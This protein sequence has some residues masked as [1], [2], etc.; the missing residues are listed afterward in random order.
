MVSESGK[1]GEK[2]SEL[3]EIESCRI[4]SVRRPIYREIGGRPSMHWSSPGSTVEL[5]LHLKEWQELRPFD[6]FVV[7][8]KPELAGESHWVRDF[9]GRHITL[10]QDYAF[11]HGEISP[12]KKVELLTIDETGTLLPVDPDPLTFEARGSFQVLS[13]EGLGEGGL[14]VFHPQHDLTL[15]PR[16]PFD[17]G[18]GEMAIA[19]RHRFEFSSIHIPEGVTVTLVSS[20]DVELLSTGDVRIEGTLLLDTTFAAERGSQESAKDLHYLRRLIKS[21]FGCRIAA[22][23]DLEVSGEIRHL[24]P[25]EYQPPPL[26]LLA[27]TLVLNG[28]VPRKTVLAAEKWQG[29]FQGAIQIFHSMKPGYSGRNATA[30]GRTRWVRLPPDYVGTI[31]ARAEKIEGDLD[32]YLQIAQPDPFDPTLPYLDPDGMSEPLKLPLKEPLDVG[33]GSHV[34]FI[35]RAKVIGGRSLPSVEKLV[36]LGH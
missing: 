23:G 6:R 24:Y 17:R 29:S 10:P 16:V 14:G 33:Q 9:R 11:V 1:E 8:V 28:P 31:S 27:Q 19:R 5:R 7:S 4:L 34:R 26:V 3:V 2:N 21:E 32:V 30:S 20:A 13:R 12:G 35:L 15:R 22:A 25:A 18:D 36:I